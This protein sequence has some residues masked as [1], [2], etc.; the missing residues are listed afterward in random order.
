M[1]LNASALGILIF[2]LLIIGGVVA[3]GFY[4]IVHNPDGDLT[5]QL[6]G[7]LLT[8]FGI[9]VNHLFGTVSGALAG[10]RGPNPGAGQ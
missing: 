5:K 10:L 8:A 1:N 7:A 2:E 6:I 9:I 3:I 4:E